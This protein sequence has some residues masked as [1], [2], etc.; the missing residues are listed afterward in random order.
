MKLKNYLLL[1]ALLM[2]CGYNVSAQLA[3]PFTPRLAGG[4]IKVK[5]DIIYVGNSILGRTT[6]NPTFNASGAVTNLPVLTAQANASYTGTANN[7]GENFEYIDV[8]GDASTFSSSTSN[9]NIVSSCKKIVYAG[10][11]WTATY[12][13]DR[14][15]T[16]NNYAEG[17]PTSTP[18]FLDF[19][20]VKLRLPGGATYID[21]TA[22]N[23]ADPAGDEDN[24]IFNGFN[25][26]PGGNP[27]IP[28][29]N[30]FKDSPYVCYKNVTGLLQG[31]TDANGTY[32]LANMRASRGARSNGSCGGWTLVIVYESNNL[33]SKYIS[34]YDGFAAIDAAFPPLDFNIN[35]FQTLPAPQPV[36]A[37]VGAVSLEGDLGLTGDSFRIKSNSVIPFSQISNGLNPATNFFNST[38]T[39]NNVSIVNRNPASTNTLGY[40]M[41]I[42]AVN[43]PLNAVIP[44]GETGATLRVTTSGDAYST[45]IATLAV[46]IIEPII[47]LTK[48]VQNSAGVDIGG[49]NV[50]LG[51][52][53]NYV[54][55]FQNIGNDNTNSFT[56]R[57]I[58]PINIVFNPAD[59]ILP[60]GVTYTYNAGTR[61]LIFTIPN[62]LVEINDPRYEIRLKVFIVT[63]CN[64][65]S[66]A[67][68]NTIQNQAF[69][70][71][72]GVL[73]TQQITN[74]P[75]LSTFS[76]CNNGTPTP[77]NFLVGV[78]DCIFTNNVTLCGANVTLTAANGY[79]SYSWSTSTTGT[80]VI[81]TGQS[82]VV[83]NS[84][85]Y[86]SFNTANAPCLSIREIY[87]VTPF[88]STVT[89]P[90][91]PFADQVVICGNDGKQLPLIFLCGASD[92]VNI[93]TNITDAASI[94][95]ERLNTASCAPAIANCANENPAC[96]WTTVGTGPNYLVNAPGQYRIRLN[97]SGGCFNIFYFNVFQNLL[98]PTYVVRDIICTTPSQITINNVPAGYEY[99][100]SASGPW[101][102]SNIF[103][104]LP[105]GSY[106][107]YIRQVG[108]TNGCVFTVPNI[109]IRTRAFT[110]SAIA[111]QPLCNG[112]LGSV[113]L[114]ANDV[115]PQ[116]TF[117]IFSSPSGTLVNT[118]GPI[119]SN[120]QSFLNLNAGNYTYTITTQDGCSGSGA[121]QIINPP[122]LTATAALTRPL[123][124]TDGQ[125]TV[126]PV[127]GTAPYE[128]IVNGAPS[129]SDPV[130]D[131]TTPGL[132][133]IQV[134]DSNNCT[135]TV[136]IDVPNNPPPT[137]TISQ[138]NVLCYGN[139]TGQIVFNV[140]NAGGYTIEYSVDNGGTFG[141]NPI[142]SNLIAGT[143]QI[144]VRYTLASSVCSTTAVN[145]VITEPASALT[146]SAGVSELAGCG[147]A[148]EGRVR[149]INPQGGVPPYE[150]S[151]NNGATY[152]PANT[153]YLAPGTYIVY[154]RDANL[155]TFPMNVTIDPAPAPPTIT[156]SP[157][158]F[159][160]TG[161]ATSTV[162]VN[163]NG[164]SFAYTYALDG[165]PNVPPDNNIFTNVPCG[166]HTVT[167]N[168]VATN[169]PT[170]S[171]LLFEDFGVGP[172]TTSPG[173]AAAYCFNNQPYPAGRP[174]GNFVAGFPASSCGSWTIE[175]NQYGVT[176]AINPNNCA[177]FPYRDHTSNGTN[178]NGRFLA[179]NI[180]SAAGPY[181]VLYSKVIN[182]ILP[183]Q[184]IL[185][186]LYLAN[187]LNAGNGGADPD[188]ILELVN[189]TGTVIA[190]QATGIID[191]LANGW[192]F[193]TL[194][195]NPGANTTLTLNLRSGSIIYGGNDAA[196]DDINVYQIPISCVTV[197]NFPINI[198][199]NQAFTAQVTG[200]TNV[201][202]AGANNGS[203]TIAA[204][205][206][207]LPAGFE[208][209]IDGGTTWQTSTTSP[210]TI[211]GLTNATYNLSIRYDSNPA[212]TACTFTF[213]QPITEPASL[214][215]SA[216]V[217]PA[218][219]LVAASIT[220]FASGGTPAYQYQL[221]NSGG[222][223]IV[224]YQSSPIFSNV[225]SGSYI[226][227]VRDTNLCT[228]PTDTPL[229]ITAPVAPTATVSA[230][231]DFCFDGTNAATIVITVSG[232]IA[233]YVY[234]INGG[235]NQTSNTFLNL[236]PGNY[237]IIVTD[238][239][240]CTV[241]V[242]TQT[243]NAQ[244]LVSAVL[245]KDLDCT[246]SPNATITGTVTGGYPPYTTQVSYNNSPYTASPLVISTANAGTYQFQ[247]TDS[248]GCTALSNIITVSPIVNPSATTT[249]TNVTCNGL[250][251]GSVTIVPS[252]GTP[253]YTI[254]FNG[255]A[256]T[257]TT[258]YSGLAAGTY[259]YI[260]R[261]SKSCEFTG[262]VVIGQPTTISGIATL[263]TDYTCSVSGIGNGVITVSGVSGG[264]APYTYSID[265][266]N[267]GASA[268]F[269]GLVNGS[270]TITIRDSSGCTFL[271]NTIVITPLNPPTDMTFVASALSCPSNTSNV[272][273]TTTG[274]TTPLSYQIVAPTA[275]ASQT[276]NV[277]N[278]LAP[279]TYTFQVTD[280][281]NCTY[282][283][284]FTIAPIP[285]LTVNG[286]L[287]SNVRCF[288]TNSGA[289]TFTVSNTTGFTYTLNTV[290]QGVGT[291]PIN[292][293]NLAAGIYNIVIT[294]TATNC[295]ATTSL[296]VSE[297]TAALAS[298]LTVTP[299]TCLANG[300][301]VVNATGGW[302]GNNYTLTPPSG[303]VVGPQTSNTFANLSLPG[304]Y[305][306]TTT[307]SNGCVVT[308]TFTLSTPV[309]PTATLAVTS[310]FCYDPTNAAT[311]VV[312]ASGGSAP[313]QY[314]INGQPYQNG[315][316]FPN[317]TP[318]TYTITVRDSF[319]CTF[320]LPTR[321]INAQLIATASLTKSLDCTA[322]PDAVIAVNITG[323]YPGYSYQVS[324]NAGAYS[325]S[326]P[327]VGS[328]FNYSTAI[329]GNYQFQITD[330]QGCVST[331]GVITVAP[332]SL[333][334]ITS[335]VQGQ[336]ILCNGGATASIIVTVNT[337]VGTP[338]YVI[339]VLNTTTSVNY[340]TQTSGLP[341]GNYLITLTDANSCTDTETITIGQPDAITFGNTVVPI[342]CTP[343]GTALGSV[344]INSVA[345]GVGP[346]I[347]TLT[348]NTVPATQTFGPTTV[349]SHTFT[350][351][352]FG[353]YVLS[354]TDANGCTTTSSDIIIS[355]PPSDLD[356]NIT[357]PPA[358]CAAGGTAVVTVGGALVSSSY[359][360]GIF[361]GTVPTYASTFFPGSGTPSSYTFTGLIPGV[362]YTF[363]VRDDISGCYYF[364]QAA[365]PIPP[366]SNLTST[367]NVV[368]N[369]TCAGNAD[370]NV[371]FTF[372]NYG[373]TSVTYQ[374][375]NSQTNTTIP[376]SGT[377]TGLTG[378]PVTVNNIGPLAPGIYYIL[379]TEN[380]GPL[381]AGCNNASTTF[382]VTQS[383]VVLSISASVIRNDNCNPLAG[384]IT[385]IGQGGTA[386]YTYQILPDISPA[387]I[388]TSSGW[389]TSNTINADA[390]NYIAYVKDNF[391][392]IAATPVIVLPL[393]PSPV[394]ALATTT[395]CTATQGN[396]TV[397]VTLT[398]AGIA[399]Y[400]FSL[401][402]GT[403]VTQT[404]LFTY[405]NLTSGTH[406]VQIRD[407]NGCGMTASITI[408][409]PI[410]TTPTITAL[411]TCASND[412]V[413]TLNSTG[414]TGAI[415]YTIVPNPGVIIT[416]NVISNIPPGPYTITATD[417]LG[418]SRDVSVNLPAGTPVTFTTTVNNV[419]CN[420]GSNG[421]ITVNLPAS[422]DNP[423][424]TYQIIAG[425]ST[426][427]IQNSNV[428][429]GLPFGTYTIQV[430]SGRG[431]STTDIATITQPAA[432]VASGSVTLFTCAANNSTN[433]AVLTING[434]GGTPGYTYSI[435][436]VNYFT[437]NTF[438]I[439][440]NGATQNITIYV[441][442]NNGC[443]DTDVVVVSPLLRITSAPVTQ[444]T[445][446][447]CT[448]DEVVSIAVVG[449]SGNYT[450]Q[451][452][453]SGV[454]Q[455]SN[456][457]NLPTTGTYYFQI[458]DTTTG[459][460]FATL[461]Y[462]VSPFN[463]INVVANAVAPVTCF[464]NADGS[465]NINV[466]GYSGPYNY[467]VF[468]GAA[469]ITTGS[470]NTA[471]NPQVITG[472]AAGTYTVQVTETGTP[473]CVF[474]SNAV[475]V[476]SPSVG[477]SL[478][479]VSNTNANCN[480]FAQVTVNGSGGTP[481]YTYAF[482]QNGA[483]P[484]AADYT[485]SNT[486]F[487]NPA[488]NTQW[489]VYVRDS[490]GCFTFIDVT[491]ATD[492]LPTVTLPLYAT[493]QCTSSG[494][495]YTFIAIGT[496][497]APLTYSIGAGFQSSPTFTVSSSG[498]YTVTVRDVNGCTATASIVIY[499]PI[500]STGVI[501]ALP[502]C[503]NN[504]GVITMSS[505]GGT[506]TYTY[507]INPNPPTAV[508]TGNVIS[509]LPAGTYT[510]TVADGSLCTR[511][512]TVT[513]DAPTP[514][515][516]T[517]TVT[518]VTCNGGNNGIITVNLNASN[519]NPPYTYQITAGPST[520][521]VQNSNVFTGLEAGSYTIQVTSGRACT[522]TQ[523]NIVVG[524]PAVVTVPTP[525]VT[526]F[527]CT[528]PSN[529]T[530]LA[531]IVVNGVAGGS[532]TYTNYQ[533]ILGGSIVQSG[534]NNTYSTANT[535]GGTYTINV[536]DS[537]G[538]LGTSAAT[539]NPFI[540]ISNPTVTVNSPITCTTPETITINVTTTGGPAPTYS[541]TV[542][543]FG[544]NPYL[545][546]Q[547][548]PTF[549]GLTIGDYQ[550]T[551]T[552]PVTGCSVQTIHY[553]FDPN[554]FD[555]L[556]N[557]VVD[558][559]CFGG[560]NGTANL[561]IIDNDVTPTNEAGPFSYTIVN[562]SSVTVA[563]GNS[564][565]A[566]PLTVT[567]LSAGI[568]TANVT[569]TNNPFCSVSQN[570]TIGQ[571]AT[572]LTISAT[573][574]PITCNPT[575][576]G[577]ITAS[578]NGGWGGP[579]QF[580][581][582][583]G[584]TQIV[585]YSTNATF[586]NLSAG[587]YTVN[588][589]DTRGCIVSTSVT[590]VNPTPINATVTAAPTLL[591][592][593]N[594]RSSVIT[595]TN[596][597]GGQGSNYTY[598]LNTTVPVSSSGPST[599]PVFSNLGAGT[600]SVTVRDGFGCEFT[601][602]DVIIAQ[603]AL[604][605]ASLV[606]TSSQTCNNQAILTL[607][608][609]GGTA[610]YTYS[611]DG[612]TY[613]AATFNPSIAISVPVGN[614]NYFIRDANG[615]VSF[616]SNDVPV[617]A[618]VPLT[619][620]LVSLDSTVECFGDAN[621]S[622]TVNA[623][624]GLGNYLYTLIGF[625]YLGA[626]VLLGPQTSGT[627][628]NL[629]ASDANGYSISV[630]SGDCTV[631][632]LRVVITQPTQ[633]LTATA[634]ITDVRCFGESS[635][636]VVITPVG[637]TAPYR[638]AIS[639]TLN[640]FFTTNT[641]NN[642]PIGNYTVLVQDANGC[643]FSVPV[644]I[645][646]P[647]PLLASIT[648]VLNERCAGDNDGTF[649][650]S[651]IS[652]GTAP[653]TV[654]YYVGTVNSTPIVLPAGTNFYVYDNLPGSVAPYIITVLD[655]NGCTIRFDQM[656]LRG[657]DF[658]AF[659]DTNYDCV[660][661]VSA[662]STTIVVTSNPPGQL[663]IFNL[664]GGPDTFNNVFTNLSPGPHTVKVQIDACE[665]FV[666]FTIDAVAPL[667]L[668][669]NP[670]SGLNQIS[671]IAAGG[672][673]NYV[674]YEFSLGGSVLQTGLSS[675]YVITQ[676]GTYTVVVTDSNGCT[677]TL[678]IYKEFIPIFIPD[679][680][681]P[682]G[683]GINEGWGPTN[684]DN[685]K[686]IETKI[687]DRYGREIA[688]LRI[689]EFWYGKYNGN[690]LPSGDYWYVI[691][692]DGRNDSEYV[693]H[694]TLYR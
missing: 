357:T 584:A 423:V 266:V 20:Q 54:I 118:A 174:C 375:Y 650:I 210:V 693:G 182:N 203:I 366:L 49:G 512:V 140:T 632:P 395:Q 298:T 309:A 128:Y 361:D 575:N 383:V 558:V 142:I 22:D 296:T 474:T 79:N 605:G 546:T 40:D 651:N 99:A 163:S 638:Y 633:A 528:A 145:I 215:S 406:T 524:Q 637:G 552:N 247:I 300:Q 663:A 475:T 109:S 269:S 613:S 606:L 290:A 518:P 202:C 358:T 658:T 516:F 212:N 470:G 48:T 580:E 45:H 382:T 231:S 192:Q 313:Y 504:D 652:G 35:G 283:E 168:Y 640:Q 58:L 172:N 242:P 555:L 498:T 51:Q 314:S 488:T 677:A 240:G 531:T 346:Y 364:E 569:L 687:F 77:T 539:I 65:L 274:G 671:V 248:R 115:E 557:N 368:N 228:D 476:D 387:P 101:Q 9:L 112:N 362:L 667:T 177:W 450:Y 665:K 545:V 386:P 29:T 408:A 589:R 253:S 619:L 394:I 34:V 189:S 206:F 341:A 429:A 485:A 344:T 543:G 87:N 327:V 506:G 2:F 138:T 213:V 116:Y 608:G 635:G 415:T 451:L 85:T 83:T 30:S 686:N 646:E 224:A 25:F 548:T 356:I 134:V 16:A 160:C 551:V 43:N 350:I 119:A 409:D 288:G 511:D 414:G 385:A 452:L 148:G 521:G 175:D 685:Y 280:S 292:L 553:I 214:V 469:I 398:T 560:T 353:I 614:Y 447:T 544:T 628:N 68:S 670:V 181:G 582:L 147:P 70:T 74:D 50:T 235:A 407:F 641:F 243:I 220:A 137:Y 672:S 433:V 675:T 626:P 179:V 602:P 354:A 616:R 158:V 239:G 542:D 532:G 259:P 493:D 321:T 26:Y 261:D 125:I 97:Y 550:I 324:F 662:N 208:Y 644:P 238:A 435:N 384:Q 636:S 216:T 349:L 564:P 391:G 196:I 462:T 634:A 454:A 96:T 183:N 194:T 468:N 479:L 682:G 611:A 578:A 533:F 523:A 456:I 117:S 237:N 1:T 492:P 166:P 244:L 333:P 173:I 448:N 371:S 416:G 121:F 322:S 540:G 609:S 338:A 404:P 458:N 201:T 39:N 688:I 190:T 260:V 141:T 412:G 622:I 122:L 188:F 267:F 568:Y 684:T 538:C 565:N 477:V 153:A 428:F 547:S 133:T 73:N 653:Y 692:I 47:V 510:I 268:V 657:A 396:Y 229:V 674:S 556:I 230:T 559:T 535:A 455:A 98:A 272:T 3:V 191:N 108:V 276:S 255:S 41:D 574:T 325:A 257:T 217:T 625:D 254:S 299:I 301:V 311:I 649:T 522:A 336:Q 449:G 14:T 570:F 563:S 251:N 110:T 199:C 19:N 176:S 537:N 185:I 664:D 599:N 21:I 28:G 491:I 88:G 126:Y 94:V 161:N 91:I 76:L 111:T 422:N 57:D 305:T 432:V 648:N 453:P 505:T 271:T 572:A 620:T 335:V 95:W 302:G 82:I 680:F 618:I 536:F 211:T 508:I 480:S 131:V 7:N 64:Q 392:C 442:D 373:G 195:L 554:T 417:A 388:A 689:G 581:L 204:Q 597:T 226:V 61:E 193:R 250:S 438:D 444:V 107:I 360:F 587:N 136:T 289:V 222:T 457:F 55:G 681:T 285:P 304:N 169:I 72:Q 594:D 197:R 374:F 567:G 615:C 496:G 249:V 403:F 339:N 154:I 405:S 114:A 598:T 59:L 263:T 31:L 46:E 84:G 367:I 284:S 482:M 590:L 155:C 464:G 440:D 89:N 592:C 279:G 478:I 312:T 655:A 601:S 10:L 132:Y 159:A 120:T 236:T 627:F 342:T 439:V 71:Y 604:V 13:Y 484:V 287:V 441:Q 600:Y 44:N 410:I 326:T 499:P 443:I 351:L 502:S 591:S 659:P 329:A 282:Q 130:I 431:C 308:N 319:G 258:T 529:A 23:A 62:N 146:A 690:E 401:D 434:S 642:L 381:F 105:A 234:S 81:G 200:S 503:A 678:E 60:P 514:V 679:F 307:D 561:T 624:G 106:T 11:Y 585:A 654:S 507:T 460:T 4:N 252:S 318:G 509:G 519:D 332:L 315:N 80:P 446:I 124:C 683:D 400:S 515:T 576:N 430:N 320:T 53:L 467:T 445:A 323:G 286:T 666:D 17:N 27:N 420:G 661:N 265:G 92:S 483:I 669:L 227:T 221:T 645:T 178:P 32:T 486:A 278:N 6:T 610:P 317:L 419:S 56:I 501:T 24:I 676:T 345:G 78:D 150:Y 363:V 18:R 530:N 593:F 425:P 376:I 293:T 209:S 157:A 294:D 466:T 426:T 583:L 660:N 104:G 379:F 295:T 617:P 340:G 184:P 348:S 86:Y 603:P 694:F 436:G 413:V 595:V 517:T 187:L 359:S 473:F 103:N 352:N 156:V 127:G 647:A 372:N 487:L 5:G 355:S 596:V 246:A 241:S 52:E 497:L 164:G 15:R 63:Q 337:T 621:G 129:V 390:G 489:D 149:I 225:P 69:A 223:V 66:D 673:G 297:P 113:F 334:Q 331:T 541:Y 629:L 93:T 402:G 256:F 233:P 463:N 623:T 277:F 275:G 37:S 494:S 75:S 123:T 100:T 102:A 365:T 378:A 481:G 170:F 490:R 643:F 424:Y 573:S 273:I 668:S 471:V 207:A 330:S 571:P 612:I 437:T 143:Y 377:L 393:D 500:N 607:T 397:N 151:F 264:T 135:I 549:T 33:S 418:C 525:T 165:V 186:D 399:P 171:N 291:S 303:P 421:I 513:L 566:G 198:D 527:A 281:R 577:T 389:V 526:Q 218:T 427:A 167:V 219:C 369:V 262:S 306:V 465:I 656:I 343:T 152:G 328:T 472:L 586:T 316:T 162:T 245:T 579:Y 461:P 42:V 270:Y 534:T 691:R 38:I 144:I 232:G 370:A 12:P 380:D 411:P 495:S 347:Y 459:C 180:G 8:D 205:N 630:T 639:P 90:V 588:V 67:C 139:N 310:D 36:R 631:P 562:S 520:T